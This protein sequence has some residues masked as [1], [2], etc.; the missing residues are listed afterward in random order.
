MAKT[1]V[2]YSPEFR[3]QMVDL[4]R[5]GRDPTDLAREFEPSS[6]AIR[7]W[8]ARADRQE[9]RR[10]ENSPGLSV[11]ER[12]ELSR[13]RRENKQLRQ[14][15]DILSRAAAWFARETGTRAVRIF[16]FMKANQAT[17]PI[18][19][20]A[21]VLDVSEGWLLC[22]APS[23]AVRSCARRCGAAEASED[24][25]CQLA[26]R[27]TER[28]VCMPSSRRR[29]QTRA[30]THC[31]P[32]ARRRSHRC[33][34][35][36]AMVAIRRSGTKTPDLHRT[37]WIAI[38]TRVART[39][40]GSPT[41]HCPDSSGFPLSRGR[42]RCLEPQDRGLGD[43]EPSPG[44]LVARCSGDGRRPAAAAERDPSQRSRKPAR[45]QP[46]VATVV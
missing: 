5:A 23:A 44:R 17:F 6:Q 18:A 13:L 25:A 27:H 31:A 9:G 16:R 2:P 22:L 20:M 24:R 30:Q 41:S 10:E 11:G 32:H 36:T 39:S 19:T 35:Q 34:P 42:A 43:G 28:R 21:R 29:R 1:H 4:V 40:F 8:V 33:Q 38:S 46:V 12:E 15:R 3:R 7:N 45:V 26:A 37:W 14:E